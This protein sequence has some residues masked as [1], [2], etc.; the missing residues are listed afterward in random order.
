MTNLRYSAKLS[1]SILSV[2]LVVNVDL[3]HR[4]VVAGVLVVSVDLGHRVVAAENKA[5]YG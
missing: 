2:L 3:V 1:N 5:P 4:V